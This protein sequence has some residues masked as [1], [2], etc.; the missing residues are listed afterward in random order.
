MAGGPIIT[1]QFLVTLGLIIAA[2]FVLKS[3]M[4]VFAWHRFS[5]RPKEV[6]IAEAVYFLVAILLIA[7]MLLSARL[8]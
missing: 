8:Y 5:A 1:S 3:T 2:V 6:F 7:A 4:L